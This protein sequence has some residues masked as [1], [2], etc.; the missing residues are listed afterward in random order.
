M[1][2]EVLSGLV[3]F[4]AKAL[5]GDQSPDVMNDCVAEPRYH[6]AST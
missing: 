1:N 6:G 3:H 2:H 4:A 5:A